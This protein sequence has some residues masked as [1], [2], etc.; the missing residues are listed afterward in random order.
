MVFSIFMGSF[1]IAKWP[2][3][4]QKEGHKILLALVFILLKTDMPRIMPETV[5]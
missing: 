1:F 3:R 2:V 4:S 5:V